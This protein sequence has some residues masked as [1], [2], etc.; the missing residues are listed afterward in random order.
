ID[1]SLI[2]PAMQSYLK[3]YFAAPNLT[4]I[5]GSNYIETRAQTDNANNWQLRLDHTFNEH[6]TLFARLSQM[7]VTDIAPV[8]GTTETTPS[9]YHAYNFGGGYYHMFSP[10]LILDVRAG[11]MLKPYVFNQASAS[12][13]IAPAT[14]AGFKN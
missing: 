9:T 4:G 12:V 6:N 13:G 11:A 2:S 7:W 1:P 10:S 8:S 3:A 14:A 5:T